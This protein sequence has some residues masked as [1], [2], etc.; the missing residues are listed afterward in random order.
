MLAA[1]IENATD[2]AESFADLAFK[3][4]DSWSEVQIGKFAMMVWKIW[5]QR[6]NKLWNDNL[7]PES[8]VLHLAGSMLCEI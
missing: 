3:I 5:K 6:N 4:M 2:G 7:L 8:Q 1:A